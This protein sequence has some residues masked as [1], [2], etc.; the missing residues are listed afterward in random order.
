MR[1]P[2]ARFVP[3]EVPRRR[4]LRPRPRPAPVSRSRLAG[5]RPQ[6]PDG[7]LARRPRARAGRALSPAH[8]LRTLPSLPS[9]HLAPRRPSVRLPQPSQPPLPS[10]APAVRAPR[11]ALVSLPR[12][13][14]GDT[15]IQTRKAPHGAS[16]R[17][18][19][20]PSALDPIRV[21]APCIHLTHHVMSL[22]QCMHNNALRMSTLARA[23]GDHRYCPP[24]PPCPPC[25]C[26]TAVFVGETET[27]HGDHPTRHGLR[28]LRVH[29]VILPWHYGG[30]GDPL[31][32]RLFRA[33]RPT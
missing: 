2:V 5:S 3:L 27:T 15:A 10:A 18:E 13:I 7:R 21:R 29:T 4:R 26:L 32:S 24:C 16:E 30:H 1:H 11:R 6:P 14:Q 17:T 33:S 22:T 31:F 20:I 12:P 25:P 19:P 23:G 28:A 9:G 8:A